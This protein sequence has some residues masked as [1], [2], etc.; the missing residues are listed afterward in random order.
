MMPGPPW[1]LWTM[2]AAV[3]AREATMMPAAAVC[4]PARPPAVPAREAPGRL[5]GGLARVNARNL[6]RPA[7]TTRCLADA[8]PTPGTSPSCARASPSSPGTSQS[9]R[10]VV[11][12][13]DGAGSVKQ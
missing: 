12:Q 8:L 7:A 9:C 10:P 5:A 4:D 1:R 6:R 11:A 13:G 3:P 2:P